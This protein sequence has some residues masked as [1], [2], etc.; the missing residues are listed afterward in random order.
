MVTLVKKNVLHNS[1]QQGSNW[2][3]KI[4]YENATV[5]LNN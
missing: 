4:C 2:N 1:G 5:S 3:F